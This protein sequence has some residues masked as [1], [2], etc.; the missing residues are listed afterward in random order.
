MAHIPSD[1]LVTA[2]KDLSHKAYVLL[3]YYYSKGET[4]EWS[5]DEMSKNLGMNIRKIKEYRSEL[6]KKDYLMIIKGGI[7]NVFIGR[8]AVMKFKNN[9]PE[10]TEIIED[11]IL[12]ED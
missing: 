2:A 8:E 12:A 11:D 10:I 1:E 7:T 4:W 6:I 9:T 5:D 3:M